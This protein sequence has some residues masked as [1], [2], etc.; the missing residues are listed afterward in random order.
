[1]GLN[2]FNIRS[3][4]ARLHIEDDDEFVESV[5]LDRDSHEYPDPYIRP[6]ETE[7]VLEEYLNRVEKAV[8]NYTPSNDEEKQDCFEFVQHERNRVNSRLT[9]LRFPEPPQKG[10]SNE[11]FKDIENAHSSPGTS[12][13]HNHASWDVWKRIM[14]MPL[15]DLR[16][17]SAYYHVNSNYLTDRCDHDAMVIDAFRFVKGDSAVSIDNLMNFMDIETYKQNHSIVNTKTGEEI[18]LTE[19]PDFDMVKETLIDIA[20]NSK[21]VI[22]AISLVQVSDVTNYYHENLANGVYDGNTMNFA[23][24]IGKTDKSA[25][26]ERSI[27]AHELFHSAQNAIGSIDRTG[28]VVD[29][30][31]KPNEWETIQFV[32]EPES[33]PFFSSQKRMKELWF[34]FRNGEFES[35][36][37]YQTKNVHEMFAV[38][39]ECW[40]TEPE[41]LK[42]EQPE[43][44]TLIDRIVSV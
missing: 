35:L 17:L 40:Y 20:F 6:I 43:V 31:V 2:T 13:T 28:V 14:S 15:S 1:M 42:K 32:D 25:K 24:P 16:Y 9:Q 38:A 21:S 22:L 8:S 12:L 41:T 18:E 44:Y 34:K 33:S 39:F 7:W 30:N 36:C 5:I 27:V 11:L 29:M 26:M 4:R 3:I 19:G 37:N 23:E 10:I